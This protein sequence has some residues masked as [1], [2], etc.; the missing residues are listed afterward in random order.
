MENINLFLGAMDKL[1]CPKSDQFQIFALSRNAEKKGYKGPLLGPRLADKH[2]VSFSDE[3]LNQGKAFIGGQMG[4]TGGANQSGMSYGAR[5]QVDG[6][7]DK[8]SSIPSMQTQG[9]IGGANASGVSYGARREI[10]GADQ[11][12]N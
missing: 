9:S 5:R 3:Q 1:G 8:G 11:G 7:H 4:F 12:K 6:G 10:G 2:E